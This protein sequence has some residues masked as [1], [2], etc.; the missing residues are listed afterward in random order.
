MADIQRTALEIR[1]ANPER[2]IELIAEW[3]VD[4]YAPA[5]EHSRYVSRNFVRATTRNTLRRDYDEL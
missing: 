5:N 4:I 3:M 2:S 1:R